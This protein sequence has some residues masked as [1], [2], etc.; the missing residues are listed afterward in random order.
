[1]SSLSVAD[2]IAHLKDNLGCSD[3]LLFQTCKR[4]ASAPQSIGV[5][6]WPA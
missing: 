3:D 4:S 1:M 6:I 2:L 5:G